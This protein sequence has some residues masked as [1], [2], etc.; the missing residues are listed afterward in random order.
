MYTSAKKGVFL[1]LKMKAKSNCTPPFLLLV[2]HHT[3]SISYCYRVGQS[4]GMGGYKI[5]KKR[6]VICKH[7][8][9]HKHT[10]T[11]LNHRHPVAFP[12]LSMGRA[13]APLNH[14]TTALQHH[15][16]A[17]SHWACIHCHWFAHLGGQKES[18]WKIEGRGV[19]VDLDKSK[20]ENRLKMGL[21]FH[22][23]KFKTVE[24]F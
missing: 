12:S 17:A 3:W 11:S 5:D 14:G 22:D 7:N 20:S 10:T 4:I 23:R 21:N 1:P 15:A 24:V 9:K 6:I 13:A 18:D 2:L 8:T 19:C 16:Q